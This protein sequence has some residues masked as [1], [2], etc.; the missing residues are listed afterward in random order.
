MNGSDNNVFVLH[1]LLCTSQCICLSILT[2]ND[3]RRIMRLV[4]GTAVEANQLKKPCVLKT[5]SVLK[6]TI[7]FNT[8]RVQALNNNYKTHDH[9][10]LLKIRRTNKVIDV[11]QVMC[12]TQLITL[13]CI[14]LSS[15]QRARCSSVVGRRIDPS[16]WT[17]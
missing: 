3:V 5:L 10:V 8:E 13:V 12:D 16:M 11:N 9:V 4:S 14:Q 6:T 15:A 2:P 1:I 17:H 7:L